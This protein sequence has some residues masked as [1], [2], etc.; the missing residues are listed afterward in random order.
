MAN[1]PEARITENQAA[2][3]A[4]IKR[5]LRP[6]DR[7]ADRRIDRI[8]ADGADQP[9][10]DEVGP[11]RRHAAVGEQ[12][13]LHEQDRRDHHRPGPRPEQHRRQHATQQVPGNPEPDRE[14]DHLSREDKRRH[15]PHQHRRPLA[16]LPLQ[17][18]Q[19]IQQP[20]RSRSR[21]SRRPPSDP[22][23][24][25]EYASVSPRPARL[26]LRPIASNHRPPRIQHGSRRYV[27]SSK[28]SY[29]NFADARPD[30]DSR[31]RTPCQ[32]SPSC[33]TL[34]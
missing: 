1:A 5:P 24:C 23:P 6:A 32:P 9:H 14:I 22:A 27:V 30:R 7:A 13:A 25:Q 34:P 19:R 10:V 12:E 16:E 2:A 29:R 8:S 3:M 33:G 15:R 26:R 18:P 20:A 31:I 11:Q 21:P 17:L 28:T 4:A